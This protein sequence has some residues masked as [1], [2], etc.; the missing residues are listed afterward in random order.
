M[1]IKEAGFVFFIGI[2]VG[3]YFKLI[4]Q[5]LGIYGWKNKNWIRKII[6]FI[7]I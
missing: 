6:K 4:I 3:L 1:C 5:A 2:L 7:K